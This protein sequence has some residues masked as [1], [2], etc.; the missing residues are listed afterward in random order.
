MCKKAVATIAAKRLVSK[1]LQLC[2]HYAGSLLGAIR[3]INKLNIASKDDFGECLH[4]A[5][6]EPYFYI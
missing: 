6:S 5:R 4:S 2:N 1:V 3:S